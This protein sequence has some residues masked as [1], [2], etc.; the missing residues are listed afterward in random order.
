MKQ[1]TPLQK[2]IAEMEE[3]ANTCPI[4]HRKFYIY[5]KT[6]A[7]QKLPYE[8]E[9]IENAYDIAQKECINIVLD[10]LK[11]EGIDM[12][13]DFKVNQNKKDAQ[14]YFNQTFKTE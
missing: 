7:I 3:Q 13:E 1:E 11:E 8:R 6:L 10:G 9:V 4:S 2:L 12:T 5:C 14:Q